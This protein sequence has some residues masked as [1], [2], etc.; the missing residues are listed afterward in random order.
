MVRDRETD[1]FK[2]FCYV[3][4]ESQKDLIHALDFDGVLCEGKTLRVDIAEG[5][6][7]DNRGG[8]GGGQGGGDWGRGGG[9]GGRGRGGY[10]DRGKRKPNH[11]KTFLANRSINLISQEAVVVVVGTRI[12]EEEVDTTIGVAEGIEED[13]METVAITE[14]EAAAGVTIEVAV[15]V[16]ETWTTEEA[17]VDLTVAAEGTMIVAVVEG[18]ITMIVVEVAAAILMTVVVEEAK[19]EAIRILAVDHGEIRIVNLQ[20][21]SSANPIQVKIQSS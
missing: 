6:K 13:L 15:T 9:R 2:G 19:A 4:F 14:I 21:K 18:A 11:I 5:R 10:E 20:L 8:G 3:E 1:R 17:T 12:E 7:N 16:T